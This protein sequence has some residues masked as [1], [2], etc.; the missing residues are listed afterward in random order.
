MITAIAIIPPN[1]PDAIIAPKKKKI[2]FSSTQA[3]GTMN[4]RIKSPNK[5]CSSTFITLYFI[6]I[7]EDS[8]NK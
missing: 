8:N 1:A 6:C 5:I 2:S 4:I 7:C 3:R